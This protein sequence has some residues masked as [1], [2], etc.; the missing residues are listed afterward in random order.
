MNVVYG[1]L[2]WDNV[3]P[4]RPKRKAIAN[5]SKEKIDFDNSK[6]PTVGTIEIQVS[7]V[8]YGFIHRQTAPLQDGVMKGRN[9][10]PLTLGTAGIPPT[11]EIK[12]V[13]SSGPSLKIS[14]SQR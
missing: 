9:D 1:P 11:H 4:I 7:K 10:L 13:T 12:L 14:I 2:A 8:D 6:S 5:N 3:C